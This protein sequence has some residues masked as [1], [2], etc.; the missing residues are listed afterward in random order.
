[1]CQN[2]AMGRLLKRR[3]LSLATRTRKKTRRRRAHRPPRLVGEDEAGQVEVE[4]AAEDVVVE[5]ARYDSRHPFI[6]E[7]IPLY[8]IMN[9]RRH[10]PGVT[11]HPVLWKE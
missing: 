8:Y 5:G 11:H 7:G 2:Q 3:R 9:S 10:A 4:V 1:M 6:E